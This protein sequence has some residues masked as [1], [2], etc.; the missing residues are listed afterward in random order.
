MNSRSCNTSLVAIMFVPLISSPLSSPSKKLN[1]RKGRGGGG[2]KFKFK[3][4][5]SNGGGTG[6]KYP[7][8]SGSASSSAEGGGVTEVIPEGKMFAGRMMGGGTRKTIYGTS[9]A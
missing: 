4:G 3:V 1:R 5:G 8:S 9:Y 7:V 6:A 2:S